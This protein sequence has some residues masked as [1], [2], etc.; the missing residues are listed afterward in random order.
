MDQSGVDHGAGGDGADRGPVVARLAELES[1]GEKDG[2]VRAAVARAA[3]G[4]TRVSG[5]TGMIGLIGVI[6]VI[7]RL[8]DRSH[9]GSHI[10]SHASGA[11]A[12]AAPSAAAS[13]ASVRSARFIFSWPSC[14]PNRLPVMR[15]GMMAASAASAAA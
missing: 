3:T 5:L 11:S 2:V 14:S 1:R 4:M 7:V 9:A 10:G 8:R 6:D 15:P 13:V 12:A